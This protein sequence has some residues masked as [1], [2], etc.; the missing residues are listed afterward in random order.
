MDDKKTVPSTLSKWD[1]QTIFINI[2]VTEC[3]LQF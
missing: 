3:L 1:R 2:G